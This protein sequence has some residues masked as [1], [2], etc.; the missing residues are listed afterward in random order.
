MLYI[1]MDYYSC[2]ISYNIIIFISKYQMTIS[3][4]CLESRFIFGAN[5][6]LL[7]VLQLC[8]VLKNSCHYTNIRPLILIQ[9]TNI[10]KQRDS[11]IYFVLVHWDWSRFIIITI[12]NKFGA[13]WHTYLGGV[14]VVAM[15][16]DLERLHHPI[17]L[18]DA[19]NELYITHISIFMRIKCKLRPLTIWTL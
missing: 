12:N 19:T 8:Q 5:V 15:A 3:N 14:V 18:P 6:S 16:T 9:Y 2:I 17:P 4:I 1:Y 11:S 10:T 7:L 13:T